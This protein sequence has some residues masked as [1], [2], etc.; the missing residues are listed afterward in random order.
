[1]N[2]NLKNEFYNTIKNN[3]H[4]FA[5]FEK[6]RKIRLF[7]EV[8]KY[9]IPCSLIFAFLIWY[10]LH[11]NLN[12]KDY[13]DIVR[14]TIAVPFVFLAL[15]QNASRVF[16]REYKELCMPEILKVFNAKNAE[17]YNWKM[18][19]DD[20]PKSKLFSV[21]NDFEVDD[22][23]TVTH[24]NYSFNIIELKLQKYSHRG[25]HNSVHICF[26]GIVICLPYNKTV[27]TN[28][29]VTTKYDFDI[30]N[31]DGGRFD[32]HILLLSAIV[33]GIAYFFIP[34]EFKPFVLIAGIVDIFIYLICLLKNRTPKNN[35]IKLEDPVWEKRFDVYSDDEIEAR[36]HVTTGFM[37]RFL[38]LKTTFGC[39]KAKCAFFDDKV[40]IAISTKKN[41]FE[42]GNLFKSCT[43]LKNKKDF[44]NEIVSI[45][46]LVDYLK[47]GE[48]TKL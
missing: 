28:T 33:L 30:L 32:I 22:F 3:Q 9:G 17:N 47:L 46:D 7:I 15:L 48:N 2:E 20:V 36:Y 40:M 8:L 1:M 16:V 43:N 24:N 34:A 42:I 44:F 29:V 45:I 35:K 6:K 25:K 14:Y 18:I 11:T 26:D 13:I 37:E 41:L 38:N 31:L 19:A 27:K 21:Y 4:I 23:F 12:Q 5:K 10:L 39:R